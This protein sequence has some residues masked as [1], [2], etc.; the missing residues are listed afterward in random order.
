MFCGTCLAI[1]S[2]NW[3]LADE[4]W[5]HSIN[6][7]HHKDLSG[8]KR[9]A[10]QGCRI[11]KAIWIECIV[12][13]GKEDWSN[14]EVNMSFKVTHRS[15]SVEHAIRQGQRMKLYIKVSRTIGYDELRRLMRFDLLPCM[16]FDSAI[17]IMSEV[18]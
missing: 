12:G 5:S 11:C 10:S 1:F 18:N 14:V 2:K 7:I 13:F 15:T 4:D 6:G 17:S 3:D 8:L 9:S 16:Q